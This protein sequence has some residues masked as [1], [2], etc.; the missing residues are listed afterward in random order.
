MSLRSSSSL[1]G[2]VLVILFLGV[3][4]SKAETS[5]GEQAG[6][7]VDGVST[8][9]L[10]AVT[11]AKAVDG[12]AE[13]GSESTVDGGTCVG[14]DCGPFCT[15]NRTGNFFCSGQGC[16]ANGCEAQWIVE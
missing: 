6:A 4:G 14:D 5:S 3:P 15:C 16:A 7:V 8:G 2:L 1:L 11:H 13:A 10:S 9:L 12:S